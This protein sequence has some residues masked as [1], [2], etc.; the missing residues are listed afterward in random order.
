MLAIVL[1][2]YRLAFLALAALILAAAVPLAFAWARLLPDEP[3]PF[4]IEPASSNPSEPQPPRE[5]SPNSQR[6]LLAMVLLI[7]VTLS[8]LIQF[9]GVPHAAAV[10]SLSTI[11]PRSFAIWIVFGADTLLVVVTGVAAC[12]S[13]LR[14]HPSRVF[15]SAGAVL[16]L[17]LWLLAP[18]LYAALVATS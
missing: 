12:Y 13:T 7:L 2:G 17:L 15:L 8:Y 18:L 1:I 16:V 10:R 14:P 5:A 3:P 9:P 11:L 6:D 4:E